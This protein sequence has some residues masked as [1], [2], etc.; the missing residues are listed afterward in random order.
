VTRQP[1]DAHGAQQA[2]MGVVAS[3]GRPPGA[4]RARD[5]EV[6][7]SDG[8][9]HGPGGPDPDVTDPEVEDAVRPE[10]VPVDSASRVDA[11]VESAETGSA[12][13]GGSRSAIPAAMALSPRRARSQMLTVALVAAVIGAAIG[14]GV[15]ATVALHVG[16]SPSVTVVRETLPAPDRVPNIN[17]IPTILARAEP[18]VVTITSDE[19]SGSGIIVGSGGQILTNYHV[20]AGA[21]Q[22]NVQLFH[23]ASY[24]AAAVAGY[25]QSDDLALLQLSGVSGL[26]A[27]TLGD[28]DQLQVGAD[29]IAVGN[30]LDLPGDPTVTTGIVS[31]LGRS[32]DPSALPVGASEPPNLIQT[33]AAI[34]PGNSGGPLLDADGDVVGVNTL[35]VDNLGFAIPVNTIKTLLPGLVAGSKE[36]AVD[37]GIGVK[38]NNDQLADEYGIAIHTGT[39]ITTV[40]QSSPAYEAGMQPYDVI[41]S[42]AGQPV[43]DSAQ[44]IAVVSGHQAGEIVPVTVMRGSKTL[45]LTITIARSGAPASPAGGVPSP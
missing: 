45:H 18:S 20:V 44:L 27:A 31:A 34:N 17:D 15:G 21:N 8:V 37:L 23:Q 24:R 41:T 38:D 36:A 29:V 30:A 26:P 11:S 9:G 40:A 22:V 32:I 7:S 43:A 19:G 1:F 3:T 33:D 42:F 35:V 6:V 16:R 28:S 10:A 12:T 39:L 4:G 13:A 2:A 5:A 25:D 14:G